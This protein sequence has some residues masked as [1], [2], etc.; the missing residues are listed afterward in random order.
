MQDK[1]FDRISIAV[2]A[3]PGPFLSLLRPLKSLLGNISLMFS[4]GV[5]K[6]H[7][8]EVNLCRISVLFYYVCFP[9]IKQHS[10]NHY[11]DRIPTTLVT[12]S[13]TA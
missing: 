3:V 6:P 4:T 2:E 10:D 12:P 1:T 11:L 5:T 8:E 9:C 7:E 13:I